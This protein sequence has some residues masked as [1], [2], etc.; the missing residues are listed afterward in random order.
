[1]RRLPVIV[2]LVDDFEKK[3]VFP[4]AG[5]AL[6]VGSK[7]YPGREDRRLR[8][9]DAEGWDM[10]PGD[11]VDRVIDLE[12]PVPSDAVHKFSH[13][14]C[15]SVLEHC[16]RPWLM[17]ANIERLLVADG[18]LF[19]TVPFLWRVHSYPDD[20]WRFTASCLTM[21]FAGIKWITVL[22][23]ESF[24]HPTDKKIRAKRIDEHLWFPCTQV[25]A[26]G[27]LK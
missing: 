19:V 27:R 9:A 1:M 4:K 12:E 11:G 20:Y 8:Y 26:F 10:L 2:M 16:K 18:T 24:L 23:A 5:K 6:I 17:A 25:F 7:V 15:I 21:L 22:Y 13:I 3:Y 14:D